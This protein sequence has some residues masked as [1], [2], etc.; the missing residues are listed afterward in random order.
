MGLAEKLTS[1][2]NAREATAQVDCGE[3]GTVTVEALPLRELEL[4]GRGPDGARKVFYAAC[5]ELQ[6]AGEEMRRAGKIF[7]PDGIL[8][9]VSDEEAQ[10][11]AR[12][13]MELSGLATQNNVDRSS[14]YASDVCDLSR[15]FFVQKKAG[16]DG[17]ATTEDMEENRLVSVQFDGGDSPLQDE[18]RLAPVQFDG[19][20]TSGFGQDS[21]E[22]KMETEV[23]SKIA[24]SSEKTPYVGKYLPGQVQNVVS[25]ENFV[26]VPDAA[27]SKA[28]VA[29]HETESELDGTLH[30]MK[31]DFGADTP[32][33]LHE[34]K[35]DLDDYLH[36][37]ES[38]YGMGLHETKSDFPKREL[39]ILH[40]IKSEY[41]ENRPSALHET[42][43]ESP[44]NLHETESELAECVARQLFAGLQRAKWV[45]GG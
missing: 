41:G 20:I 5:R 43:S 19:G 22:T 24:E 32:F 11:A 31:S 13:V 6:A 8:Q 38:E 16:A 36:E 4:L 23:F 30:E 1:R 10:A 3:L 18:V 29:L 9:Y 42:E 27:R 40:E 45:R 15:L 39:R 14:N 2:A 26:E 7:T 28:A 25:G 21:R 12:T 17:V 33:G 35:S 44:E 34:I 37:T